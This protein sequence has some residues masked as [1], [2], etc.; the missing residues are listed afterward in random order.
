[1]TLFEYPDI[2]KILPH[3]PPFLMVDRIIGFEPDRRIVGIKP[4]AQQEVS[5]AV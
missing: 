1:M 2:T 5:H 4:E 3:R